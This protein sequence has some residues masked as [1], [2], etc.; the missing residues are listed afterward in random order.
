MNDNGNGLTFVIE[1]QQLYADD[2]LAFASW[3]SLSKNAPDAKVVILVER[4]KNLFLWTKKVGVEIKHEI[5][6][7]PYFYQFKPNTL[8]IREF[9]TWHLEE[10]EKSLGPKLPELLVSEA[11]NDEFTPF[12][13]YETCGSFVMGNWI[14]TLECPFSLAD[15]FMTHL[16]CA[17]E[18]R[19]L[20]L[21]KQISSVYA[22]V[23]RG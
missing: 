18:V 2:W 17:N 4:P 14:N 23:S 10:F 15:K 13:S 6:L 22:T 11:K 20:R 7:N 12:V 3:Y 21:W 8:L 16:A 9:S 19:I 1:C 5:S